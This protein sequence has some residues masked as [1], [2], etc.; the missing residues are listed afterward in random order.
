MQTSKAAFQHNFLENP[1]Q[2]KFNLN[3][4]DKKAKQNETKHR[5]RNENTDNLKLNALLNAR[6]HNIHS[7]S[8]RLL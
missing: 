3:W 1:D 6:Q 7:P 8:H 4:H 2:K 5:R